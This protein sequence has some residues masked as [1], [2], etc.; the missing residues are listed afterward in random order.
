MGHSAHAAILL[1]S[2]FTS[3]ISV[4]E[5]VTMP[6]WFIFSLLANLSCHGQQGQK[7]LVGGTC[8]GCEIMYVGM[9]KTINAVDT[10]AGWN[11]TGE[12]MLLKGT[13]FSQ[14]AKTPVPNVIIYYYHTD[15]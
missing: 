6:F 1:T 14:D 10:S 9:P 7:P 13:V 2:A 15:N 4:M 11:E 3:N 12:K 8:E 5:K